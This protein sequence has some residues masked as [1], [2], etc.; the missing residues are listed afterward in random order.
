MA[1]KPEINSTG[2][3]EVTQAM[4]SAGAEALALWNSEFLSEEDAAAQV[5]RAMVEARLHSH[6]GADTKPLDLG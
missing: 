6:T 1:P 3:I 2:E 4:L 5:Y